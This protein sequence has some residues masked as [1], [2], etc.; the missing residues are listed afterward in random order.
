M[1]SNVPDV[2]A[3]LYKKDSHEIYW[4]GSVMA[5]AFRCNCYLIKDGNK[6]WVID[7][8][9][10]AVFD[11]IKAA[12]ESIVP[13]TQLDGLIVCH[14]DPDVCASMT[15]WLKLFPK[16]KIYATHRT[17]VI[18][19]HYGIRDYDFVDVT[20]NDELTLPSGGILKFIESPF[21]HFP[22][23]MVTFDSVSRSLFSGDIW[24]ALTTDWTLVVKDMEAHKDK[25][26][27]FHKGY[28]ASNLAARGFVNRIEHLPI[29]VIFP[30]HGSII[31]QPFVGDALN[32]MRNLRCGTDLIYADIL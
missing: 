17:N 20:L 31:T 24:A 28:M 27:L 6:A 9:E 21:L 22:G 16:L 2:P 15:E 13:L 1:Y 32:Y 4:L 7:P 25:M 29:E 26:D 5:T 11:K 12:V 30:Q 14:S 19:P 18:L 8:G 23:A 10:A 3:L